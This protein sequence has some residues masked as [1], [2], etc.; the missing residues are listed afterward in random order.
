M[1]LK[2][3]VNDML[4]S[5]YKARFIA[6]YNQLIIRS[7]S[8]KNIIDKA[9]NGKLDFS[10]T[11]PVELLKSQYSAMVRYTGILIERASLEGVIL[12]GIE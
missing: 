2:D 10:L 5:D 1:E 3:T 4:S 9:E 11:C 6:E 12:K 7:R 8:L